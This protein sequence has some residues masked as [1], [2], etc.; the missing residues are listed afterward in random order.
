M[1]KLAPHLTFNGDCAEAFNF[2]AEV[3]DG[4]VESLHT[5][6]DSPIAAELPPGYER[7]VLHAV[8]R[9]HGQTIIGSDSTPEQAY[10][11]MQG[12]SL[13]LTYANVAQARSAFEALATNGY[14]TAPFQA[15]PG[16]VAF[17]TVI[18]RFGTPWAIYCE[19]DACVAH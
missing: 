11:E 18:D 2:Y 4:N 3:L 17:G 10:E 19:H 6:G 1:I 15:T 9:I 7:Q 14:V 5:F 8:I 13:S 16:T 12:I